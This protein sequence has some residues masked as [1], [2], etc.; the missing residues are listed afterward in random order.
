M[1]CINIWINE[2]MN[3]WCLAGRWF[4]NEMKDFISSSPPSAFPSL[5]VFNIPLEHLLSA[6]TARGMDCTL[7]KFSVYFYFYWLIRTSCLPM[8]VYWFYKLG[9]RDFLGSPVVRTLRIHCWGPGFKISQ[10]VCMPS[11]S[12]RKTPEKTKK[13]HVT[14]FLS[15]AY[16]ECDCIFPSLLKQCMV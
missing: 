3:E 7:P 4:W 14:M 11:P 15:I 9:R 10:A 16:S 13:E 5:H 2:W 6:S 1:N 12:P 8:S